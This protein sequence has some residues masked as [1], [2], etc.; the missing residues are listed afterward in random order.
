MVEEENIEQK[1][2]T[3]KEFKESLDTVI[4]YFEKKNLIDED[5]LEEFDIYRNKSEDNLKLKQ[6]KIFDY[7]SK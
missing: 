7:T 5:V 3:F 4:G 1:I 6:A 2:R